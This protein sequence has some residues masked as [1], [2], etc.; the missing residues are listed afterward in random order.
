[1][2]CASE[3]VSAL[4]GSFESEGNH[5]EALLQHCVALKNAVEEGVKTW[6]R[7]TSRFNTS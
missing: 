3:T 5:S 4:E 2:Q 7:H 1:M 6:S